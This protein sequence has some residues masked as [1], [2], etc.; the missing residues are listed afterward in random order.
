MTELPSRP[1]E[2]TSTFKAL[3]SGDPLLVENKGQKPY[4]LH[5]FAKM[6]WSANSLPRNLSDRGAAASGFLR[7]LLIIE[8]PYTVPVDQV[9]PNLVSELLEEK[10]GIFLWAMEGLRRLIGRGWQF[11]PSANSLRLLNEYQKES[12]NVL[13]FLDECVEAEPSGKVEV[14]QLYKHY[15]DWCQIA[16]YRD[17]VA[18]RRFNK[19]VAD[20]P[21]HPTKGQ[22]SHTRRAIWQGIRYFPPEMPHT[23]EEEVSLP[24]SEDDNILGF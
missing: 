16:G 4:Q 13:L 18:M 21:C 6:V 17:I 1:I 7:R 9:N 15:Q 10:T 23:L 22:D 8:M 3:V 24:I 20:M 2:D 5:S 11:K 14:T 19:T 12:D